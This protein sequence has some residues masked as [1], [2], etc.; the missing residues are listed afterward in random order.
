MTKNI[1]RLNKLSDELVPAYGQAENLAGELVRAAE[2]IGYRFFNDGDQIGIGYG[3]ETCNPAARFLAMKTP[4]EI[5]DLV[6]GLWGMESEAGYQAVLDILVGKV[7]DYIEDNPGL[8]KQP[9]EDMFSFRDPD[10]DVDDYEDEEDGYE[11]DGYDEDD[12]DFE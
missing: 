4:K 10:E 9:T 2:R 8:R 12:E 1:E 7:A 11:E 6:Y 3:K 5:A